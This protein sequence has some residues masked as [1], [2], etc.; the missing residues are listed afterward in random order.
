M[1]SLNATHPVY[2]RAKKSNGEGH[3]WVVDG[4][5]YTCKEKTTY[6]VSGTSRTEVAR[7]YV[8]N[9]FLHFNYGW[10]DLSDG[11]YIAC[12]REHGSGSI[13]VGGF[14][15][16]YPVSIFTGANGLNQDVKIIPDIR[17]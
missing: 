14:Y 15:D 9:W 1:N 7:E 13:I 16:D 4:S 8:K 6:L 3:A 2:I 5:K 10:G 12:T 17:R 11:Y